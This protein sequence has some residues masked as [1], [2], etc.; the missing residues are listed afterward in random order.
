[1]GYPIDVQLVTEDQDDLQQWDDNPYVVN[2]FE[3]QGKSIVQIIF[4]VRLSI[5]KRNSTPS[6]VVSW[7]ALVKLCS[8]GFTKKSHN[9][10]SQ[11]L[12][13]SFPLSPS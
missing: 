6:Q 7:V 11:L 13:D 10:E 2:T 12:H 9:Q 5:E 8:M 1:M 4:K 3:V